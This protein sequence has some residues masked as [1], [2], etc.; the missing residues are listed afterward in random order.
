MKRSEINRI[1]DEAKVFFASHHF[2]LP[3]W[4]FWKP[5]DWKGK[6]KLCSEIVETML[7]WDVT[8]FGG[9]DFHR[10][11]LTLFTL[12]NGKPG[13]SG[14][15]YAEKIMIVEEL[16]ET[17][18]HFHWTKRE[19]IVNRGGGNLVLE[20]CRSTADEEFSD[21]DVTV[22]IDAVPRTVEAGGKV[23]LKPGESICIDPRV[24]HRF[25]GEPGHGAVLVGE[26]SSVNDDAT[27]NRFHEELGR[28]PGIEEDAPPLHLLA[29]DYARYL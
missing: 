24:Y 8:P 17:P 7:G 20:L 22:G 9:E 12:R 25:Y 1:L 4:A 21:E 19:D 29:I 5:D 11:G 13:G 2:Y 6:R 26:V 14:K 28:F 18:F 15:N 16:Q 10:R 27:D 23:V 3:E